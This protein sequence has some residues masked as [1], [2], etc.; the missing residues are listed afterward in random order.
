MDLKILMLEF[1]Y[2]EPSDLQGILGGQLSGKGQ[3]KLLM[4][5][6]P[7]PFED[8]KEQTGQFL[9]FQFRIQSFAK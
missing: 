2:T 3:K 4:P 1:L 7:E 5:L 9:A 8:T 6:N